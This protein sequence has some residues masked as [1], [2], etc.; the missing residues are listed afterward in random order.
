MT[1]TSSPVPGQPIEVLFGNG[2]TAVVCVSSGDVRPALDCLG[3]SKGAA[4]RP[5][6]LVCGGAENLAGGA[7]DRA[8]EMLV[9]AIALAA[10]AAGALII[11][12]GTASGVMKITGMA[13][14]RHPEAL[15]VLIG[16]APAGKIT[17]PG[18]PQGAGLTAFQEDHSH[19]LLAATAYW[20]GETALMFAAAQALAGGAGVVLAL[21][22]GGKV[23]RAEVLS[24]VRRGWP[25][26]VIA[27][28]GG[29]ADELARLWLAHRM[30]RRR[31]L[32]ALLPPGRKH[33]PPASPGLIEELSL[34]EIVS[35][36]DLRLVTTS[37]AGELGLQI[38]AELTMS[39]S[40]ATN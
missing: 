11:D 20:G 31:P 18:G 6:L 22:G 12:G 15:P 17:Y 27:G 1:T 25:V 26:F 35:C 2:N 19:F 28:T 9:P 38:A 14:T 8:R 36:G 4:S 23:A 33:R 13:R 5:V 16:V 24:A 7:F 32:A 39:H 29:L 37:D 34:R 10:K 3:L 40:R 30:P 21:A